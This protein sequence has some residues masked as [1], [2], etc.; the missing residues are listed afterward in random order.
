VE[1]R[2]TVCV[3]W[4]VRLRKDELRTACRS[5]IGRRFRTVQTPRSMHCL[6]KAQAQGPPSRSCETSCFWALVVLHTELEK[7]S[8]AARIRVLTEPTLLT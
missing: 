4:G 5:G 7:V 1:D 6:T 3:D 2:L 8:F